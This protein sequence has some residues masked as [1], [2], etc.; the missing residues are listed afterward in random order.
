[1][2]I[3]DRSIAP[4]RKIISEL[5]YSL[6]TQEV[7]DNGIP[8]YIIDAAEKDLL[9]IELLFD[10]GEWQQDLHLQ[11][12]TCVQMLNEGCKRYTGTEIADK[13]DFYGSFV[14]LNSQKHSATVSLY[15]LGQFL[16]ASLE[17]LSD[18]LMEPVFPEDEFSIM[19]GQK[20]HSFHLE[21]ER[22]ESIAAR[23]FMQSLFGPEHPYGAKLEE[24]D[25]K[26]IGTDDLRR[27]HAQFYGSRN[28]RIIV[29]G[30]V[31]EAS[32]ASINRYL[33]QQKW[34]GT[35][36]I[37]IE[38]APAQP[39][40]EHKI[41]IER[42]NAVQTALRIGIP[43]FNKLHPDYRGM[44]VLNT[45][46]GGY[47]GSRLMTNIREDKGYTYGIHSN[48]ASLRNHGYFVIS[49]QVGKDVRSEALVE[50]YKE[51]NKLC[52]ELIPDDELEVV[53][54]YILGQILRNFDGPF[55]LGDT[56]KSLL[57]YDLDFSHYRSVIEEINHITAQELLALA[58]KYW[59]NAQFYE[60]AVG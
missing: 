6:P 2:A 29:S 21:N 14:F 13:L 27:F 35:E 17:I 39:S 40:T 23:T 59:G 16:D 54:N 9:R 8:V 49:S 44:H 51:I 7:L 11:A 19:M 47:F 24:D 32:I 25:F 43:L 37:T 46:L 60:I 30:K 26:H 15:C 18:M 57:D 33:G 3:L 58:Q 38:H 45:I 4:E 56:F 10:A 50:I 31:K 41:Y 22:V 28:C 1:M 34:G 55:N 20:L 42:P 5:Q 52:T 12:S 48:L 36:D 53:K